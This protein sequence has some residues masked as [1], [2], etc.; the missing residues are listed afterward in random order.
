MLSRKGDKVNETMDIILVGVFWFVFLCIL[1]AFS[2]YLLGKEKD[3]YDTEEPGPGMDR[4][5]YRYAYNNH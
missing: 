4:K 2:A 1:F 3:L 5:S